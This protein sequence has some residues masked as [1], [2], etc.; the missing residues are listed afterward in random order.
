MRSAGDRRHQQNFVA[1]LK[2]VGWPAEKAD[3][4]FVHIDVQEAANLALVITQVRLEVGKLFVE[5]RKQF[6]E[7]GSCASD[8]SNSVGMTPQ[9]GWDLYRYCHGYAPTA[10][11]CAAA[12]TPGTSSRSNVCCR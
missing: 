11:S 8:R 4:F 1:F 2:R 9:S 5:H 3:V 6:A 10:A 12:I 7:V